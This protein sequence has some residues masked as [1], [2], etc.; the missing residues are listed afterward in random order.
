MRGHQ[1]YG[2]QTSPE[3]LTTIIC[4]I[5][6]YPDYS[7]WEEPVQI[8]K[9]NPRS[10][11]NN[12]VKAVKAEI[13]DPTARSR[14]ISNGIKIGLFLYSVAPHVRPP[15][16]CRNCLA[17]GHTLANCNHERTCARC[18]QHGHYA[19]TCNFSPICA[20]CKN[21]H[22]ATDRRC[23]RYIEEK[24]RKANNDYTLQQQANHKNQDNNDIIS[25]LSEIKNDINTN[26]N[27]QF[28]STNAK[29]TSLTTRME[30]TE[31]ELDRL[32]RRTTRHP[33]QTTDDGR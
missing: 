6:E 27:R 10:S 17:F 20:N 25:K 29:I 19:S 23:P 13:I 22:P 3:S 4:A 12:P 31:Q 15:L 33:K 5:L 11:Y 21:N 8:T 32:K 7:T 28:E 18:S 1:R 2:S 30:N 16:Q 9:T 26:T 14:L 24:H